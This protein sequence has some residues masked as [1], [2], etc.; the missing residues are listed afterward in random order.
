MS[1]P[2]ALQR[3]AAPSRTPRRRRSR[4]ARRRARPRPRRRRPRPAASSSPSP[5][6]STRVPGRSRCAHLV[7]VLVEADDDRRA[8]QLAVGPRHAQVGGARARG[9]RS[10]PPA[11]ARAGRPRRSRSPTCLR[12]RPA[13]G[14]LPARRG[15]S[16]AASA[17]LGVPTSARTTSLGF[18]TSTAA[19]A[20]AG[21]GAQRGRRRSRR[22][23][24][25]RRPSGR[26]WRR[27]ARHAGRGRARPR[28]GAASPRPPP[29]NAAARS[30]PRRRASAARAGAVASSHPVGDDD[31]RTAPAAA[32]AVDDSDDRPHRGARPDRTRGRHD[33]VAR[34][35]R[36]A[37]GNGG[38]R[39]AQ[40]VLEP[41][42]PRPACAAAGGGE[43]AVDD[44]TEQ[45]RP[46]RR[47]RCCR[48]R[49]T[50]W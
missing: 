26:R 43:I 6:A 29:R 44:G 27:R 19:S 21:I 22:G 45:L 32:A 36:S 8:A 10:Q 33:R 30:R 47:G 31:P 11:R 37:E 20:A 28:A 18:G 46:A 14:A 13:D 9:R 24:P 40:R 12:R 38:Q 48:S 1:A 25:P 42:Q 49:R 5:L 15:S 35:R 17:T 34:P 4:S 41:R 16:A 50:P 3:R 39:E 2:G 23:C 7:D